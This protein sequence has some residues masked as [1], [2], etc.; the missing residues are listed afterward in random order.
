ML[1]LGIVEV[2]AARSY[3]A[4]LTTLCVKGAFSDNLQYRAVDT[5][6]SDK[7][8]SVSSGSGVA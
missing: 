1:L 4:G 6:R 5:S 7:L 8:N 2:I 3:S